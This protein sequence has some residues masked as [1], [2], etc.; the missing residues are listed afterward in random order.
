MSALLCM[1]AYH[2]VQGQ[3]KGVV[4]KRMEKGAVA[5]VKTWWLSYLKIWY[6]DLLVVIKL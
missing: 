4:L 1:Q 3:G 5:L 6:I 2:Y